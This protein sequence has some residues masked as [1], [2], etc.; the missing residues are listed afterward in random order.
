[1]IAFSRTWRAIEADRADRLRNLAAILAVAILSAWTLWSLLARV[2]VYAVTDRARLEADQAPRRI[3]AP[4][5]SGELSELSMS[6]G[7]RVRA[8]DVL[9]R[10]DTDLLRKQEEAQVARRDG[11]VREMEAL[12]QQIA[13]VEQGLS[14]AKRAGEA[15][16]QEGRALSMEAMTQ[17]FFAEE[18]AKRAIELAK[19]GHISQE[20]L[21]RAKAD[22]QGK[23][24]T[25]EAARLRIERLESEALAAQSDRRT[26]LERLRGRL[27]RLVSD[28]TVAQ[29]TVEGLSHVIEHN[30][31]VAPIDGRI[32]EM[33][34][35]LSVGAFVSPGE[36][37]GTIIPDGDLRVVALFPPSAVLGRVEPGQPGAMHLSAYPWLEYGS[38][39]CRVTLVASEP[40]DGLVRVEL[41]LA[42]KRPDVPLKHGLPGSLQIRVEDVAPATLLLRSLGRQREERGVPVRQERSQVVAQ[43]GGVATSPSPEP[44]SEGDPGHVHED[45]DADR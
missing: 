26:E 20:E 41:A 6:L 17:A 7:R 42:S 9:A 30:E 25:A 12:K 37:L 43:S 3:E 16:L 24:G 28:A 45:E 14:D 15:S 4:D 11:L 5:Q 33:K 36:S 1:M 2:P 10:L 31:I 40:R 13:A 29:R 44:A 8:G 38:L 34:S 35:D 19:D 18:K 21:E 32:G 23:R 39:P 22:A 27:E